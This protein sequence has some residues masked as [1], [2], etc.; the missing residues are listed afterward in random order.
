M[1]C[2]ASP[3]AGRSAC[4]C[5]CTKSPCRH[6][7]PTSARCRN[8][9]FARGL[10]DTGQDKIFAIAASDAV[11]HYLENAYQMPAP[12]RTTEEFLQVAASHVWLHG[13]LTTLL[14]RFLEFCDLAKFAGQQF[15]AEEREQL[16]NAAREFIEAAEKLRQPANRARPNQTRP[17]LRPA[18]NPAPTHFVRPVNLTFQDPE[19]LWLLLALPLL[20]F[21]RGRAGRAAAVQFSSVAIARQLGSAARSRAGW[22]LFALR[23]LGLAAFSI[24]LARPQ[25]PET[26]A[27]QIDAS[28]IDIVL[29]LDL[30]YSM[31]SVDMSVDENNAV[32]RV[33]AAKQVMED[34]IKRRP[35]DRIGMVAFATNPYLVSPIT[36]DHDWLLQ[37]LDRLH[38]TVIDGGSTAIGS[39][40]GMAINRL[41]DL[42]SKSKVIILLTDGDN[43]AGV[44]SP[45]AAAEAAAAYHVKIY[46]IGVG[47]E[48]SSMPRNW[49]RDM[50]ATS[51]RASL[52]ASPTW[53]RPGTA[54]ETC[55]R[56]LTST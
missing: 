14:R 33:D 7:R 37:N 12:E 8:S 31:A 18:V 9:Q 36:L 5:S 26:H 13:E 40:L 20:L 19:F 11:R 32:T 23:A 25:L 22:F 39:G 49:S 48:N 6:S 30:S 43:N 46:T 28:G 17:R 44:I 21:L 15:G 51:R 27:E 42:D 3:S 16:L 10:R 47:T 24:A 45:M 1:A 52:N 29:V 41:R 35:N 38:L 4:G 34:F 53:P 55:G 54:R 56:S 50:A 2:L